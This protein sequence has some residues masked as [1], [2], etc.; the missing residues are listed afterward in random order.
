MFFVYI[1]NNDG[2]GGE[3]GGVQFCTHAFLFIVQFSKRYLR[4]PL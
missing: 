1:K 4:N 2:D 3:G